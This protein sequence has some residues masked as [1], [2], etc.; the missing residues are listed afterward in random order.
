MNRN[1]D[2]TII[3]KWSMFHCY[4][5][6]PEGKGWSKNG[7][8][9]VRFTTKAGDSP[10]GPTSW[11][12]PAPSVAIGSWLV[13]TM[14]LCRQKTSKDMKHISK[15]DCVVNFRGSSTMIVNQSLQVAK[16]AWIDSHVTLVNINGPSVLLVF[17]SHQDLYQ[18]SNLPPAT[19]CLWMSN[20]ISPNNL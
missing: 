20:D 3:Y 17:I 8:F 1:F 11:V 13:E 5:E 15:S 7:A 4:V 10:R 18:C 9:K 12:G 2:R 16:Q 14:C 6:L 19:G